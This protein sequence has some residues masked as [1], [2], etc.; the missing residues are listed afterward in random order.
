MKGGDCVFYNN[1]IL[2]RGKYTSGKERM[3]LHGSMGHVGGSKLRARNVLQHGIGEWVDKIDLSGLGEEEKKRAEG[4][5]ERLV[6]LGRESGGDV[7]F[8]LQG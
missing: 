5:R 1:N 8:S 2:H 7:G 3:T 6:K 4:M